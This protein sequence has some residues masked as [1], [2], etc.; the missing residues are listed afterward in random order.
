MDFEKAEIY[1]EIKVFTKFQIYPKKN[2]A[3]LNLQIYPKIR[4]EKKLLNDL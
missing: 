2:R 4:D 3:D 1:V